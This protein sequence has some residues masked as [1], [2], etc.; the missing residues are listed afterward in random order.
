MGKM[1]IPQ[2]IE[3][4][5]GAT[6]PYSFPYIRMIR[7]FAVSSIAIPRTIIIKKLFLHTFD[8]NLDESFSIARIVGKSSAPIAFGRYQS[9][10]ETLT[11]I[12]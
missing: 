3:Y 11:A 2:R 1:T 6:A 12:E 7:G 10:S 4:R 8:V 9:L 5:A